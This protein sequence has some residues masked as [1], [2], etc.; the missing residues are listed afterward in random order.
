[1]RE[2]DFNVFDE[3]AIIYCGI[4]NGS[5]RQRFSIHLNGTARSST[6]RKGLGFFSVTKDIIIEIVYTVL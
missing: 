6:V 4:T 3:K 1:M 5:L 2:L